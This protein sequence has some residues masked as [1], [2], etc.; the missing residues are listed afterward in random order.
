M[1][2][3]IFSSPQFYIASAIALILAFFAFK[4]QQQSGKKVMGINKGFVMLV[5]VIAIVGALWVSNIGTVIAPNIEAFAIAPLAAAPGVTVDVDED[6]VPSPITQT[7][8]C[9]VEDTSVTFSAGSKY[10]TAPT[11]GTHKYRINGGLA[12][13]IA[14]AGTATL[15]PF[16]SVQVLWMNA[17]TADGYYGK[18]ENF[19]VP[20]SGTDDFETLLSQNGSLTIEV[21]NQEGNLIDSAGENET[22]AVGDVISLR[23]VVRGQFETEFPNGFVLVSEWNKT[24][25]DKAHILDSGGIELPR[26]SIPQTFTQGYATESATRAY[27]FPAIISTTDWEGK[28]LLDA[29]DTVDPGMGGGSATSI[30][31]AAVSLTFFPKNVWVDDDGSFKGPDAEDNDDAITRDGQI[32]AIITID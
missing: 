10:T 13:T 29:D 21:F 27:D 1:P 23:M 3:P 4:T 18:I 6:G 7:E 16:D 32:N 14:D 12:K 26:T 31:G 17:S 25:M 28:L 2:L 24:S 5:L 20:C 19:I 11:G 9:P 15:S 22:L 8:L 30:D